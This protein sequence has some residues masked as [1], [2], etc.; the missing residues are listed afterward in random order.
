VGYRK[1]TPAKSIKLPLIQPAK[2]DVA[3][4]ADGVQYFCNSHDSSGIYATATGNLVATL[5]M[6]RDNRP[7]VAGPR[8]LPNA[9]AAA[10]LK[11]KLDAVL[12]RSAIHSVSFSPDGREIAAATSHPNP[13]LLCW[14][15]RGKLLEEI[16]IPAAAGGVTAGHSILWLP[17]NTGWLINGVLVDRSSKRAV[18]RIQRALGDDT[19]WFAL[20]KNRLLGRFSADD[21]RLQT[22]TIPWEKIQASLKA[23]AAKTPAII[24]PYQ[25][26][27]VE[28]EVTDARGDVAKT[29]Q[30]LTQA[31]Q[32]R[33]GR[34]GVNVKPGQPTIVRVTLSEQAGDQLPIYERQSRFDFIGRDTGRKA[35]EAKGQAVVEIREAGGKEPLWRDTI[36]ATNSRS[37]DVEI[38]DE[39]VRQSMLDSLAR[40]LNGVDLP[41]FI[42]TAEEVLALPAVVQ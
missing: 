4:T 31:M 32:D 42:P 41:Y 23:L 20:D 37:F 6:S 29:K 26:V 30:L 19:G 3:F 1:G 38:T 10:A 34:D 17:E 25:P 5:Q 13:R 35:T 39:S 12:S 21:E 11:A 9:A 28:V 18:L 24:A 16:R 40:S 8:G 22:F 33:L 7:A 2:G 36:P 15:V 27:T 14:N